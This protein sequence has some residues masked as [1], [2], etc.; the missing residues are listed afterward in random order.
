MGRQ[1]TSDSGCLCVQAIS[2]QMM[3]GGMKGMAGCMDGW[4]VRKIEGITQRDV[5][6]NC[7]A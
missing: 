2:R 4:M 5:E 1:K 6:W 3:D 7:D